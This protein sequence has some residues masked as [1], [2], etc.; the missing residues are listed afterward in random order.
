MKKLIAKNTGLTVLLAVLLTACTN[1]RVLT[2]HDTQANFSKY[3]SYSWLPFV[4]SSQVKHESDSVKK[5]ALQLINKELGRRGCISDAVN[6]SFLIQV[7]L[8]LQEK[9]QT[10]V[11]YYDYGGSYWYVVQTVKYMQSTILIKMID[12]ETR[13]LVWKGWSN[14]RGTLRYAD[15]IKQIAIKI[16]ITNFAAVSQYQTRAN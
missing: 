4:D 11:Q 7:E 2:K 14:V 6:P 9:E 1:I 15:A 13:E 3:K 5:V 8:M 16:P 12:A 10:N